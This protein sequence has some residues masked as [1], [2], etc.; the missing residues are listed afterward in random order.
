MDLVV[1]VATMQVGTYLDSGRQELGASSIYN[2]AGSY[3]MISVLLTVMYL[4]RFL[5][6][7]KERF[8]VVSLI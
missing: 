7:T 6:C 5:N 1:C 8:K 3:F 2:K 4:R